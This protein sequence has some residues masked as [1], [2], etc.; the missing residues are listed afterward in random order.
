MWMIGELYAYGHCDGTLDFCVGALYGK[1]KP[2]TVVGFDVSDPVVAEAIK[3]RDGAIFDVL[4]KVMPV[5]HRATEIPELVHD[6][7]N[8]WEYQRGGGHAHF[9]RYRQSL[10]VALDNPFVTGELAERV[11]QELGWIQEY[12]RK[13][14]RD[15]K[16]IEV[17]KKI[18]KRRRS[19]FQA[20]R[21]RLMLILIERD[22]YLCAECGSQGDLAIDHIVP[23]SKGGSDE[24]D[25]LRILC[26][27]CNSRKGDS[28]P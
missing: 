17:K 28:L 11:Q 13:L 23:L 3:N 14:G 8:G 24:P 5:A 19:Q 10:E 2:R 9:A 27:S 12:E 7:Y 15:K 16:E 4:D 21:D 1:P 26:R 20:K 18:S 22:G 25:N 6:L